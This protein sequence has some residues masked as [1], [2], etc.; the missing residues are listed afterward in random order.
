VPVAGP[1]VG[2][3]TI[4]GVYIT[5]DSGATWEERNNL[6]ASPDQL[7]MQYLI[8]DPWWFTSDRQGTNDPEQVVLWGCGLGFIVKSEDAG[9]SW[10]NLTQNIGAIPNTIGDS[11]APTSADLT[12]LMV[13]GDIHG[14]DRFV[15]IGNWTNGS[16]E[17]RSW[18]LETTDNGVNW[19]ITELAVSAPAGTDPDTLVWLLDADPDQEVYNDGDAVTTI[20]NQGTGANGTGGTSPEF[21]TSIVNGKDVYRFDRTNSEY[22]S[23]GTGFGRPSNF[24]TIIFLRM[25]TTDEMAAVSSTD[26]AGPD[27]ETW[28]NIHFNRPTLG[29][30]NATSYSVGDGTNGST[31]YISSSMPTGVFRTLAL[32]YT[33]GETKEDIW[34]NGIQKTLTAT[35]T[36]AASSNAGV[37]HGYSMGR[38]GEENADYFDGDIGRTLM[39]DSALTDT[40][41]E[42]LSAWI[43]DYYFPTTEIQTLTEDIDLENGSTLYIT[44]WNGTGLVLQ[45]R[46]SGSFSTVT[47]FSPFGVASLAQVIARTFWI[48]AYCPPF[49]GTS[50]LN[51]IVYVHGR[52][53]DGS[54]VAH[55]AKSTDGGASFT[56]IGD[57]ATWTTGWVGGFFADDAN[58]LYAFVNGGSRALYRSIDAG[59]NWTNLSSLPFD[60]EPGGASKHPDGRILIINRSTGAQMAA[61][62]EGPDYSSW[63]DATGSPSF[64]TAGGGSNA[65]IWIT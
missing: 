18:I 36:T 20:T 1:A 29:G 28:G 50:G 16:A 26:A 58:T 52:W 49:F 47:K 10:E 2:A 40:Q 31:G 11:P 44:A 22:K 51:E 45:N 65:V 23:F 21:K 64:P 37:A 14:L 56:D 39:V 35:P 61:Y 25:D 9:K 60:I 48:G 42:N 30:A 63:V 34:I 54:G 53:D 6:L 24:T 19:T 46:Q 27:K 55:I 59:S 43:S 33:N 32:R 17:E 57:S 13:H 12:Y 62:A 7:A 4:A 15:I 41:I 3:D 38:N 8:W 5:F